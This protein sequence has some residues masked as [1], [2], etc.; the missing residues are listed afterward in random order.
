MSDNTN[1]NSTDNTPPAK[2][3]NKGQPL[4]KIEDVPKEI[5]AYALD[6]TTP[7]D[8]N[9]QPIKG[10]APPVIPAKE[11]GS[12]Y[13]KVISNTD[14]YLVQL[15]GQANDKQWL[16]VHE[17]EK[18]ALQ[19]APLQKMDEG[20]RL[21]NAGVQIHYTGDKAKAYPW[22]PKDKGEAAKTITKDAF[23][24]QAKLYAQENIKNANQR[25]AFVKHLEGMA[26]KAFP[27]KAKNQQKEQS[28][29]ER[30]DKAPNKG[31]ER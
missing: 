31:Q 18:I 1:Q 26:D 11:N 19:G 16:V 5:R 27:D 12:Y 10:K 24:E 8:D 7:K 14:K 29:A 3:E 17:K 22:S 9:G 4:L 20:K 21:N 15:T 13:G 2:A 23:V 28:P 25:T 30:P 6:K